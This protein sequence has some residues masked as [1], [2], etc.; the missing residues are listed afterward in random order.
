MYDSR[1]L[2]SREVLER[3]REAFGALLFQTHIA[4]TIRFAEAPVVGEAILTYAPTSSGAAAYRALAKEVLGND[5]QESQPAEGG[6]AVPADDADAQ[7]ELGGAGG[8][9]D[10]GSAGGGAS[11]PTGTRSEPGGGGSE[12]GAIGGPAGGG[13]T[14][15][16]ASD[17]SGDPIRAGDEPDTTGGAERGSGVT[18][19]DGT[20]SLSSATST[21]S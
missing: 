6:R 18:D 12:P 17:A 8:G 16:G 2:H 11:E 20:T 13:E 7:L 10:A 9:D 14:G 3:V 21:Q 5:D 1:T 4:R 15:S 19:V